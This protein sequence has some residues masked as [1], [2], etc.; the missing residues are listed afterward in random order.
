MKKRKQKTKKKN[1]FIFLFYLLIFVITLLIYK[2]I[3]SP[4][5]TTNGGKIIELDKNKKQE[6]FDF[7]VDFLKNDYPYLSINEKSSSTNID[8]IISKHKNSILNSKSDIEYE[9]ELK[10]FLEDFNQDNLFLINSKDYFKYK[11]YLEGKPDSPWSLILNDEEVLARYSEYK[12]TSEDVS[13]DSGISMDILEEN[14]IAYVKIPD[15]NPLAVE[16][17]NE[18]LNDF[19]KNLQ[20]YPYLI[21]DIRDNKGLSIEYVFKNIINPLSH[22]TLNMNSIVLEKNDKYSEF[23]NYY[24]KYD[25]ISVSSK[26][27]KSNKL[28]NTD[29]SSD[30]LETFK[31]Y[32]EYSIKILENKDR[33]FNGEIYILQNSNT[34]NAADFLSQFSNITNFAN[35]VGQYT[36]GNGVNLNNS[37]IK[38]P[39]SNFVISTPTGMGINEEGSA[40]TEYGTYPEIAVDENS[41]SLDTLKEMLN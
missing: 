28:K 35:T 27:L 32:K 22:T 15:F 39:Y 1:N 36:S 30:K 31:L 21:I 8:D 25:Y 9:K 23:L 10:N 40:N 7:L 34:E 14:K 17:D 19:I 26:L 2:P 18:L 5:S 38:L 12:D 24:N 13:S 37:F 20:D 11:K 29:I 6:E 16:K 41:N 3:K 33:T 4:T